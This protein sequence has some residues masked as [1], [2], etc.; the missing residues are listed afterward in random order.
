MNMENDNKIHIQAESTWLTPAIKTKQQ[1]IDWILVSLG[2][3]LVTIELSEDQLNLCI[4]NALEKYTK[5]AYFGPDKYLVVNLEKYEHG[6]GINLSEFNIAAVKDMA[7]PCDNM[8]S[9]NSDLF[10]GPFAFLGQGQGGGFPFFNAAGG[11]FTGNWTTWHTV[12]EFFELSKRMTGS[13]PDFQYDKETK[14]LTLMPEPGHSY[15]K[16][17]FILL[18]CQVIPP[19]SELYGNEYLKRLVLA[20]AKILLGQVRSKFTGVQLIGGGQVDTQIG[21]QGTDELN[22]IMDEII[23]DESRGQVAYIM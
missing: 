4:Q 18:T 8:M 22:K 17:N 1:L 2:Y 15:R 14:Y 6:K 20:F 10:W 13:N 9:M 23:K 16:N 12:N 11:T 7:L 21:Q 3:P 19:F 5:Y